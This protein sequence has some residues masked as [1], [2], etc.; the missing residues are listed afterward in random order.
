MR[1]HFWRNMT[2]S[3]INGAVNEI[4][5]EVGRLY[6]HQMWHRLQFS[7][8]YYKENKP[9]TEDLKGFNHPLV[10]TGTLFKS[11]RYKVNKQ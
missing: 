7:L 1:N 3:T 5:G 10:D 9:L 4:Y 2:K 8:K 6:L 11:L